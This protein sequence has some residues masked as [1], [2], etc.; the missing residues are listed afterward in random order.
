LQGVPR[1]E[2]LSPADDR[3][4][5]YFVALIFTV[6]VYL[7]Y[8]LF[9]DSPTGRVCIALRENEDRAQML[10]YNVFYFQL[11][12][13]IVSAVTAGL[14]G[15]LHTLYKPLVSPEIAGLHYTVDAFLILLI[16]G[17]GTL[18]GA[19]VGAATYRLLDFYL[20]RWFEESAGFILGAVYVALVL[21]VPYGI[22]GT[23][24]LRSFR[25]KE[26]W[27][28]RIGDIKRLLGLREQGAESNE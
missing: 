26:G 1:P 16:G 2:F 11:A 20:H 17:M 8:R 9:V 19:I 24:K 13:L 25:I 4:V 27:Q 6:A 5:F 10:G 14:A 12:A 18:S 15:A 22:V 28:A 7:F 3:L 23:W 21:F